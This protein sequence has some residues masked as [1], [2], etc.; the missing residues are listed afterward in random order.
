MSKLILASASP[1]RVALLGQVGLVPD[2]VIAAD[3]DETP[4]PLEKPADLALRL[5]V[6]KAQ[7]V[8]ARPDGGG[9]VLAADTV[10]ACGR[11]I[12]PKA[13]DAAEVKA[14]LALLSGR[15]HRVITAICLISPDGKVRHRVV[16]SAVRFRRL[17]ETEID[18]YLACGEGVGKAG[19]YAI[20][21]RAAPFVA[22]ISG[23]YSAIVGLPLTETVMLLR[24]ATFLKT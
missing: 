4:L 7:A 13:A 20:Q 2:A 14:C 10:V 6:S 19:G 11:R 23:S 22:A 15:R 9:F 1:R 24:G 12:L 3:L 18:A 5:A 17:S 8:A 16:T 21:G